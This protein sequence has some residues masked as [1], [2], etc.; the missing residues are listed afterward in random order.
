MKYFLKNLYMSAKI[1]EKIVIYIAQENEKNEDF[2]LQ[3]REECPFCTDHITETAWADILQSAEGYFAS[4]IINVENPMT[5]NEIDQI[6]R[7][8][9]DIG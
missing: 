9:E 1:V 7:F 4:R 8:S 6:E 2:V 5:Q 3:K